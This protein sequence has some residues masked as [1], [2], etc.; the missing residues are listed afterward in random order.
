VEGF[1]LLPNCRYWGGSPG[2]LETYRPVCSTSPFA[3]D[4]TATFR[5]DFDFFLST[6]TSSPNGCGLVLPSN[7]QQR[8]Q[9][10]F[11]M[12]GVCTMTGV[13]PNTNKLS[14]T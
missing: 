4:L 6:A 1:S 3:N 2:G 7:T 11:K 9:R 13:R 5:I 8:W 14:T 10:I 12:T